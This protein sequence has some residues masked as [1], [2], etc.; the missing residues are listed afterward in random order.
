ML[1][2]IQTQLRARL[3]SQSTWSILILKLPLQPT[4]SLWEESNFFSRKSHNSK[5]IALLISS[6]FYHTSINLERSKVHSL[7]LKRTNKWSRLQTK[8][9]TKYSIMR[10]KCFNSV[11]RSISLAKMVMKSMSC[12]FQRNSNRKCTWKGTWKPVRPTIFSAKSR[13]RLCPCNLLNSSIM[14]SRITLTY[15][16]ERSFIKPKKYFRVKPYATFVWII[17]NILQRD[18]NSS[19]IIWQESMVA[20][21]TS[22]A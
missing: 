1:R 17:R 16:C 9:K 4:L 11:Y 6:L 2:S 19:S 8:T 13:K 3:S 12:L 14:F 5:E 21:S 22:Y 10:Q 15:L 20:W 7:F 18:S